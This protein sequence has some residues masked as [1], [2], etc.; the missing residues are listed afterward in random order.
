[1]RGRTFRTAD[2]FLSLMAASAVVFE[3]ELCPGL[4]FATSSTKKQHANVKHPQKLPDVPRRA[5]KEANPKERGAARGAAADQSTSSVAR[6]TSEEEI[7][8]CKT[9]LK[10]LDKQIDQ[11]MKDMKGQGRKCIETTI[12]PLRNQSTNLLLLL[13]QLMKGHVPPRAVQFPV[14]SFYSPASPS[15]S[16]PKTTFTITNTVEPLKTAQAVLMS[17]SGS[18][19]GLTIPFRKAKQLRLKPID[20]A[21][22][23]SR[24]SFRGAGNDV[25]EMLVL[26]PAVSLT[27][28]FLRP[29]G[30]R[31]SRTAI[32]NARCFAE[33]TVDWYQAP[34]DEPQNLSASEAGSANQNDAGR[35]STPTSP[36]SRSMIA[37]P[38]EKVISPIQ[39]R[40]SKFPD[41]RAVIG[42]DILHR[43]GAHI[44]CSAGAA[45][46]LEIEEE[47]LIDA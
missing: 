46:T 10:K 45:A 35:A 47:A 21:I 40:T 33:D 15:D 28:S 25:F 7:D 32:V 9:S 26:Q 36:T 43:L 38:L 20:E 39:H 13:V 1:M 3:C 6:S 12:A 5:K 2:F 31:D 16:R 44:N 30:S 22:Q 42:M 11:T 14:P 34:C 19:A 8:R 18:N 27:V 17:D 37:V 23:G 41:E 29:D 4:T 24:L